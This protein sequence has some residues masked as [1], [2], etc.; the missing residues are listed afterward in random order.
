MKILF[1]VPLCI[2][3]GCVHVTTQEMKPTAE[4]YDPNGALATGHIGAGGYDAG[5]FVQQT[6]FIKLNYPERD[7]YNPKAATRQCQKWIKMCEWWCA[8]DLEGR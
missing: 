8:E 7:D 3:L 6:G 1:L 2:L 4:I 5:Q